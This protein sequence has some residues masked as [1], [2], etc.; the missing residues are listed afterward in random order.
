[1]KEQS[2]DRLVSLLDPYLKGDDTMAIVKTGTEAV[3]TYIKLHC[4][5][6]YCA[7][8]DHSDIRIIA[9]VSKPSFYRC[10]YETAS[11][12]IKIDQLKL[13]FPSSIE[14]MRNASKGFMQASTDSVMKGCVGA[15]DGY[16]L[17]IQAP[18]QKEVPN[19]L[20][21]ELILDPTPIYHRI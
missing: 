11:A 4:F 6:R 7:G 10:V 15:L 19:V 8:G 18:S 5:L 16:L 1:M 20:D 9:G 13:K 21:L 14:E 12:I 2:Y 17:L 3:P